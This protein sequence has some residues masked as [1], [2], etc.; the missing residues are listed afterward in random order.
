VP[1]PVQVEAGDHHAIVVVAI[2]VADRLRSW[3]WASLAQGRLD[4]A[5][6][7]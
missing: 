7:T 3:L 6:P 1:P 4:F 2:G 5:A